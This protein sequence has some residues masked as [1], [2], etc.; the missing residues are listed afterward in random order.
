MKFAR[1]AK[2]LKAFIPSKSEIL[3]FSYKSKR[4]P[5]KDEF[6]RSLRS[7]NEVYM[8]CFQLY[9]VFYSLQVAINGLKTSR[10]RQ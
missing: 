1:R 9:F 2:F 7:V 4:S 5:V 8:Y 10:K 3:K 6:P